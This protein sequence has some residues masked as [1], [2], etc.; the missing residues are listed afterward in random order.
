MTRRAGTVLLLWLL[1]VVAGVV[2]AANS[3]YN[4]DMSFFLPS[5]PTPGQQVMVDQ[6][7][8]GAV[9]RLLMVGIEGGDE[10]ARADLS[11]DL[12]QRLQA[13]GQFLSVQNGE[14][15][16]QDAEREHL[17]Q[18]RYL[19]SPEVTP[20]RFT[21]DGLKS[22]I[23]DSIDLLTS[24]AGL[25]IKP[26]LPRDP[27][28]ELWAQ[29]QRLDAGAEPDSVEGVWAS[30]DGLR[31]LL[32]LQTAA[33]GSDTDGQAQAIDG[34]R[35]A[36]DEARQAIGVSDAQLQMSGPG[37]FAV[38][39]RATIKE[40]VTRLSLIGISC[41]VLVLL[42][43]YR[44]PLLLGLGL[45]PVA[46]GALAGI[47]A[48][49]LAFGTVYG[50]TIGFGMALIGEAVDYAIY[51]F[52]Q[53]GPMGAAAW[54]QR[55]WPTVRLGVLTSVAGF[56][57]L[58]FSG[59]PGLAQLGLY[60]LTGVVTAALV[61][62]FVL[63]ELAPQHLR[64]RDLNGLGLLLSRFFEGLRRARWA[65]VALAVV[66]AG[67]LVTERDRLWTPDIAVLSPA[68]VEDL[69]VDAALRADMGAP[70]A[71]Y[72]V[73][74]SAAD[75]DTA[76]QMAEQA[77]PK[78]DQL[79]GDGVIGSY[80]NP[81]RFLP[82]KQTQ[83]ARQ[84]ALPE[85]DVL[86]TRLIEAQ[87]DSPL[88][89]SNLEPF[90]ADVAAARTQPLLERAALGSSGLGLLVDSLLVQRAGGWSVL[91]PLHPPVASNGGEFADIDGA[92]VQTALAG[93][94][95]HF[96]D[97][98]TELDTL[99]DDYLRGAITLSLA[100]VC[101]IVLLLGATLRSP[102]RLA[103]VLLPLVLAIVFVIAGLQLAG[104]TLHLLHLVGLL[105]VVAV[106]SNYGLFFDRAEG[107]ADLEPSTVA[108]MGV[109][110]LTTTLG[111][112]VLGFSTVPVLHAMGVTVGPGAVL[113]LLL[114]AMFKR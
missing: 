102:R 90:I 84:A 9:S 11:V 28:G 114:A 67:Y 30:R 113:V 49:S 19:L 10:T 95:A 107:Q 38:N 82:S 26:L 17:M 94:D 85:P 43:V 76:L 100:G 5:E 48:V 27:T 98:K 80:D 3:R 70:D 69:K 47:V 108:A 63:P 46:S 101:V 35:R 65:V 93:T 103:A 14:A 58:L 37:L 54:R 78:L 7:K 109:A 13:S 83:R 97:L 111:F 8:E 4:A 106:G 23:A 60:A 92:A 66:A 32:L 51:Y 59:F 75:A 99:Y 34:V 89:A 81:A 68:S 16:S 18:H 88:A 44:S 39:A 33:E 25:M 50:I 71:R 22:A 110:N 73:V 31:A 12:R 1:A 96:I 45:L 86:R 112:G 56:G 53:S 74:L 40:E 62:R 79:V 20:Q 87:A 24:P 61:T 36:F 77:A 104:E 52:V 2:V 57:A 21:V 55:F 42:L 15:G 64:G 41:I 91:L 72:M 29:I 6:L 105:L